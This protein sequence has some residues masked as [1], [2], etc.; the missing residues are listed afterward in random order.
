M[1]ALPGERE[2]MDFFTLPDYLLIVEYV[3]QT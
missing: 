3:S 1:T 2:A